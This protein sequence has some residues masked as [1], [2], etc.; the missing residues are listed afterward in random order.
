[1]AWAV[2][3]P[4]AVRGVVSLAG[5]T[6]PWKGGVGL[7]YDLAATDLLG[8]LIGGVARLVVDVDQPAAVVGRIFAPDAPPPGYPEYVG[9]S[10]A[11]RSPAFR[12]NAEDLTHLNDELA[13]LAPRYR[14]L[15]VPVEA[16]HGGADETVWAS[17]HSEPLTRDVAQ[18][19]LTLLP[20]VGHMPHH[21]DEDAVVA[22]IL[23]LAR[24]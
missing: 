19:R 16:V 8:P 9:V 18:G 2:E 6:Y 22:A 24:A 14:G 4:G 23:R 20:G 11:L 3:T 7:L 1:M 12:H 10:L 21:T 15:R 5:A 13:Q 17:V